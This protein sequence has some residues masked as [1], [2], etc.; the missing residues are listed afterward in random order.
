MSMKFKSVACPAPSVG[1]DYSNEEDILV[2]DQGLSLR[3]ILERFTRGESLPVGQPTEYGE[4]ED[5]DNPMNV[6]L[7]KAANMDLVEKQE[8]VERLQDYQTRYD[9][10]EK[11][12]EKDALEASEKAKKLAEEKRIRIAAK[13]LAKRSSGGQA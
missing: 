4:D 10:Q 12:K 8:F 6:D 1:A 13:K 11:R 5:F 2:P 9:A 3:E 7:E